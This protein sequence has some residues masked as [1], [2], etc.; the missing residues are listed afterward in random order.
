MKKI[1]F[2]LILLAAAF[3]SSKCNAVSLYTDDADIVEDLARLVAKHTVETVD[4]VEMEW[5]WGEN[6]LASGM[7]Y[8][9]E[10]TGEERFLVFVRDWL[11]EY[12]L[13]YGLYM[14]LEVDDIASAYSALLAYDITKDKQYFDGTK[15]AQDYVVRG[16]PRLE[17]GTII[18]QTGN[19]IWVDTAYMAAPFMAHLGK[20]KNDPGLITDAA[21]QVLKIADHTWDV[22]TGLS[23][24]RWDP[25]SGH[26]PAIWARGNAWIVMAAVEVLEVMPTDH[27]MG[28]RLVELLNERCEAIAALQDD[29]GLWHTVMDNPETYTE[30]SASAMFSFAFQRGVRRAWLP[31][32]YMDNAVRALAAVAEHVGPGGRVTGV[33]AGTI[34]GN[35]SYYNSIPTGEFPWGTGAVLL[36]LTERAVYLREPDKPSDFRHP[37]TNMGMERGRVIPR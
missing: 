17:D 25:E 28:G 26:S 31:S 32:G 4:P 20:I 24:H 21:L 27:P 30:V 16:A 35:T 34:P 36:A 22:H 37:F 9:Y 13:G 18:H 29:S 1:A 2:C 5:N 15:R 19:S 10:M 11:D 8:T 33:S 14:P 23:F 6:L 3:A 12:T 7:L